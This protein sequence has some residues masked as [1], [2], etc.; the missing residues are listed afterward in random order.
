MSQ[1]YCFKCRK[2][3]DIANPTQVSLKNGRPATRGNCPSC[4]T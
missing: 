2:K 4:N 1:A 3:T